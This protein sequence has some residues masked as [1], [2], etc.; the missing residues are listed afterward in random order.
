MVSAF[1][2]R[3][4]GTYILHWYSGGVKALRQAIANGAY[5]SINT[6]MMRSRRG[7]ALAAEL[8]SERVL[9]ETDG[10][11]VMV[12]DK[13]AEPHQ[14]SAVLEGLARVWGMTPEEARR[15]VYKNFSSLVR[16]PVLDE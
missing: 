9:T 4:R 5:F 3:F 2:Q 15:T 8:P 14:V 16:G 7:Q 13:A 11:F 12:D 1:G 6:A 10:P